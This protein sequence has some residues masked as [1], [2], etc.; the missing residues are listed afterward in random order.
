MRRFLC[1]AL[2]LLSMA[3]PAFAEDA[4]IPIRTPGELAAI[5]ENPAGSYIL[6]EDLDMT[7]IDWK[8]L[9]FCGT[10][11]GNGKAILNLTI[12]DPGDSI[13]DSCDGNCIFYPS[14]YYGLFGTLEN[15]EV[16][17]LML[18]NV[19]SIITSD[20][21]CFLGGFAGCM[22][23]SR[24]SGCTVS[25]ELELR[26]HDRMFGVGGF[27]GYGNG[28]IENCTADM[29]LITVDTDPTTKDEQ[30]L[31]GVYATGFV[32]TIGCTITLDGYISEHGYVHSGGITGMYYWYPLG[33]FHCGEILNNT[34]TGCITFYEDNLDRRAYCKGEAGEILGNNFRMT[35]NDVTGFVRN[36]TREFGPD[37]ELRPEMCEQPQIDTVV[38]PPGC[39]SYGWTT[40]TC[41][42]CGHESRR[43]YTLP[44]HSFTVWTVTQEPTEEMP[45]EQ[46]SKCDFCDAQ[47]S[48]ELPPLP[49]AETTE[50]TQPEETAPASGSF[51]AALPIGSAIGAAALLG[52]LTALRKKKK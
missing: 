14:R 3:I 20:E 52:I 47:I 44:A 26:A 36:E 32:D 6:M 17:D 1:C 21:P 11:D 25:G 18:L 40:D 24:I 46:A 5:A 27:V 19:R 42:L 33:R 41:T 9:D 16:R 34:V 22:L 50:E 31:G 30:F 49:P 28:I 10:F 38:T 39:T 43:D 35:D 7:G 45:G 13:S 51:P 15:A 48:E 29:T 37:T 12:T 2:L 8:S 23:D 4:P